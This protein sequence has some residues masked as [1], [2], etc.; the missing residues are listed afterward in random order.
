M[1]KNRKDVRARQQAAAATRTRPS[2]RRGQ[3]GTKGRSPTHL[4]AN[5]L[6]ADADLEL[7]AAVLVLLGP[8]GVV[9]L[10]DL[11][12]AHDAAH[13]VDDRVRHAHLLADQAVI[14][15]VAVI[16]IPRH[17]RP[18]IAHHPDVE[19]KEL[20]SEA[21]RVAR[22][23]KLGRALRVSEIPFSGGLFLT[24]GVFD[25][26]PPRAAR[27]A[28]NTAGLGGSLSAFHGVDE[29]AQQKQKTAN[30]LVPDVK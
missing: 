8:L 14:A 26:F 2:H 3:S 28:R 5:V 12:R 20:V 25:A 27:W 6:A 17:R 9:L 21:S 16:G 15:V 4:E 18:P 10:H 7:L 11:A 19:F 30:V 22:A 1:G 13:L 23:A 24:F 29:K